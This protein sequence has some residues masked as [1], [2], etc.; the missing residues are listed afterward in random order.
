MKERFSNLVGMRVA[1]VLCAAL[2]PVCARLV[3]AGS[4][5]RRREEIGD[6][7]LVYVARTESR[8]DT[9]DM[10]ASVEVNLVDGVIAQWERT[11]LLERRMNKNGQETFGAKNK[12]MRHVGTGLPVDLFETT[13]GCWWNYLVCRTG[14]AES[15]MRIAT[16]ALERGWRWNPYGP[17]FTREDGET[18]A[19]GSEEEVFEFVGLPWCRPEER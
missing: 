13:E 5:R 16:A 17:G 9:A 4:L 8:P 19:M 11:G 15:N 2:K 1:A 18:R 3:V 7:E 10:F 12:L 6:L 14:P